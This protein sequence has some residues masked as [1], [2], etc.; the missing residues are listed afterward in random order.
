MDNLPLQTM[1]FRFLISL[2][3]AEKLS[4]ESVSNVL[5]HTVYLDVIQ[6]VYTVFRGKEINSKAGEKINKGLNKLKHG[7]LGKSMEGI[8]APTDPAFDMA[9]ICKSQA[10]EEGQ[11]DDED[12]LDETLTSTGLTIGNRLLEYRDLSA[13][14]VQIPEV[15]TTAADKTGSKKVFFTFT[16]EVQRIDITSTHENAEDL[17]WT[18]QR[19]YSEFYTL[20]YVHLLYNFANVYVSKL[21]FLLKGQN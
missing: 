8:A 1:S 19:K 11:D 12:R 6:V 14:R 13:W 2:L 17:Q 7:V 9:E 10:D 4:F 15:K 3:G 21:L 16:I 5:G 20:E 18:V